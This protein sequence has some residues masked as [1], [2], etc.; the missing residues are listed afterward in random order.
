MTNHAA[1]F[2]DDSKCESVRVARFAMATRFE[3]LLWENEKIFLRAAGEEALREIERLERQLN[4]FQPAS[5]ISRINRSAAKK[6]LRVEPGLF[7]LPEQSKK[8]WE[9]TGGAFDI[10]SEEGRVR[11][12][13]RT[14]R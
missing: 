7:R 1:A 12:E 9:K 2:P 6:P 4:L 3:I 14:S 13:R 8:L 11:K 5:E 10:R